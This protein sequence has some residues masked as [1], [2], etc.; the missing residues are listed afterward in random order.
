MYS[1]IVAAAII[2]SVGAKPVHSRDS[3]TNS[4]PAPAPKV[5]VANPGSQPTMEKL[6]MTPATPPLVTPGDDLN[7]AKADSFYW[8]LPERGKKHISYIIFYQY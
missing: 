7:L 8:V 5:D 1:T 2:S 4:C 3:S 6:V